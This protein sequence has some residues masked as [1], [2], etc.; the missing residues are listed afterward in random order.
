MTLIELLIVFVIIA[1]LAGMLLAVMGSM[2]ESANQ[3]LCMSNLR[4]FGSG[5]LAF[6]HDNCGTVPGTFA[7]TGYSDRYADE[8]WGGQPPA[9]AENQW[10]TDKILPFMENTSVEELAHNN[11]VWFCPNNR[12]AYRDMSVS[13]VNGAGGQTWFLSY[14]YFGRISEWMNETVGGDQLMDR[15]PQADRLMMSD[16]TYRWHVGPAWNLNHVKGGR[17]KSAITE[18][19]PAGPALSGANQLWGDGS[20][21]WKTAASFRISEIESGSPDVYR[22]GVNSC[23]GDQFYF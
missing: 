20:V 7:W 17:G 2:R 3:V 14:T 22:T 10:S 13:Y 16:R 1:I 19:T 9:I 23:S 5:I 6:A 8:I 4:Q 21:R 12:Q 18:V 15:R 11:G